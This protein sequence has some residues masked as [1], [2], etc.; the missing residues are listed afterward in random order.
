MKRQNCGGKTKS[1]RLS[2]LEILVFF[3]LFLQVWALYERMRP[4]G[5]REG[6]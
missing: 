5:A 1:V 4:K 3:D 2:E 6:N